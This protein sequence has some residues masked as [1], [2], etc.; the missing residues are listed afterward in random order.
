MRASQPPLAQYVPNNES[1]LQAVDRAATETLV[2]S[3]RA[4]APL[5]LA[6]SGGCDSMFLMH[7]VARARE[8]APRELTAITTP[9]VVTFDHGTGPEATRAATLV[10]TEAK[11]L[12]FEIRVGR[13]SLEGASESAWREA[14]WRF[15]R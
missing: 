11:R 8:R 4:G 9:R 2:R 6:V 3:A 14:R 5:V 12:G 7:A 1:D 13:G 15:F 10:R